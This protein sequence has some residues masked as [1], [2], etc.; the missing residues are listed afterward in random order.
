MKEYPVILGGSQMA[1][2]AIEHIRRLGHH[3]LVLDR[4]PGAP[5]RDLC[6][7]FLAVD[8]SDPTATIKA[9]SSIELCGVMALNDFGVRT[10]AAISE[11]RGLPGFSRQTA[12]N[13][14]N[15]VAM[16]QCWQDAGLL[17]PRWT[18][19]HKDDILRG[20]R[21]DWDLFPCI[22][23]P[24]FAGGGSRG[25][26]LVHN[27]EQIRKRLV[28]SQQMYIDDELLLEEYIDGTEHTLEVLVHQGKT[29]VLNISDKRNYPGH[30]SVV[31]QLFFT[32]PIGARHRT[33]L[34]PLMA[35]ASDALGLTDGCAH[36]EVLI[37]DEKIFLLEVGGRPGGGLNLDP[38]CRLSAGYDYP[39][40]LAQVLTGKIPTLERTD[41]T[42]CLGWH[43]FAVPPGRLLKID[44]FD[45]AAG[46][47][48]VISAHLSFQSGHLL[49][50][51]INDLA[52][53]GYL[54]IKGNTF[55]EVEQTIAELDDRVN[56]EVEESAHAATSS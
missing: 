51:L 4:N 33:R 37:S 47:D 24:A 40:Q 16:K 39:M 42:V 14:T 3:T 8:F 10:A 50:A 15:K 26:Y 55:D 56:F 43:F 35:R 32:G 53:P 20:D 48:A 41:E 1:C 31:Q 21:V 13:V 19:A 54:L 23:K 5:A 38:I 36:Y 49:P 7:E 18:W 22:M 44:G 34:E 6:D 12:I 29:H 17:I 27:H 46:H 52:R 25:V 30:R 45:S 2:A 11:A 9:L 28:E